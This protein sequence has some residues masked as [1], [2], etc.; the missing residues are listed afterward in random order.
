MTTHEIAIHEAGHG[1]TATQ[2]GF[3]VRHVQLHPQARRDGEAG[4]CL[5]ASWLRTVDGDPS[6]ALVYMMS[7][8]AAERRLTGRHARG[9]ASDRE[10]AIHL[11]SLIREKPVDDP[12]TVKM[13]ARAETI[14][15]AQML[16]P[17]TWRAIERVA[18]ALVQKHT[19]SGRDVRLLV[20]EAVRS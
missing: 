19:L 12:E 13:V 18:A 17:T 15:F 20:R 10:M 14:A 11:A 4:Q 16:N 6:R 1:V 5:I 7:G 9:D 2:Y 8:G 3:P